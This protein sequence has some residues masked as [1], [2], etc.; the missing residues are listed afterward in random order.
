[1]TKTRVVSE[2]NQF[3]RGFP[4]FINLTATEEEYRQEVAVFTPLWKQSAAFVAKIMKTKRARTA[5]V[6]EGE[7]RTK[8]I[9]TTCPGLSNRI[10]RG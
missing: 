1:M 5:R 3:D 2:R 9:L 7:G 10:V 6:R 4:F 8:F